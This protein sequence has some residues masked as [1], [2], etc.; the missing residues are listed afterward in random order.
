MKVS[1]I[2]HAARRAIAIVL[3]N[4][5]KLFMALT[6][7]G[8]QKFAN[9]TK[10]N[11]LEKDPAALAR[12]EAQIQ[13]KRIEFRSEAWRHEGGIS[14]R[15]YATYED[16]VLHQAEKLEQIGGKPLLIQ[17]RPSKCF[18]SVSS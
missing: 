14:S 7:A 8:W 17:R 1:I 5:S 3:S 4:P 6:P 9:L 13:A 10:E 12:V 11:F 15:N 18:E 2:Y 16:Y